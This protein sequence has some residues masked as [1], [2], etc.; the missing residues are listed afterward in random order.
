MGMNDLHF[1][2]RDRSQRLWVTEQDL[3]D[4]K[5][6]REAADRIE[7]LVKKNNNLI[8]L[9]MD[10]HKRAE[11]IEHRL[12]KQMD[13]AAD[14]IEELVKE[15]DDAEQREITKIE[16]NHQRVVSYLTRVKAAE[17]KLAKAVEALNLISQMHGYTSRQLSNKARAVLAELEKT[18]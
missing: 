18:E 13:A 1:R 11:T 9:A 15:R 4:N 12:T 16:V 2:L 17:A 5:L 3:L 6:F 7:E 8:E 14:R 10:E